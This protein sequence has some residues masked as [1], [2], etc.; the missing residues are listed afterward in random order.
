MADHQLAV[1]TLKHNAVVVL[2][3]AI[4]YFVFSE[5][6]SE[7]SPESGIPE[8][9]SFQSEPPSE[10]GGV[11]ATGY[12]DGATTLVRILDSMISQIRSSSPNQTLP[13]ELCH[14]VGRF[15]KRVR[16]REESYSDAKA[17]CSFL[18][19]RYLLGYSPIEET[20]FL[21]VEAKVL[22]VDG[23]LYNAARC[24]KAVQI[25]YFYY[26]NRGR[27]ITSEDLRNAGLYTVGR[28]ENITRILDRLPIELR[29]HII[30]LGK[31]GRTYVKRPIPTAY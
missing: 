30:D 25:Y 22:M 2:I 4:H 16:A 31:A 6:R 27:N 11:G 20:V 28:L 26:K 9:R 7:R 15:R 14:L 18:E 19:R 1:L 3:K 12:I 5:L 10:D 23:I 8:S 13:T 17:L 24:W 29:A 21:D